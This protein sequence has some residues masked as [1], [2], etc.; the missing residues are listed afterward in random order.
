MYFLWLSEGSKGVWVCERVGICGNHFQSFGGAI[1]ELEVAIHVVRASNGHFVELWGDCGGSGG[2]STALG[3][4]QPRTVR[5]PA[6]YSQIPKA[7]SCLIPVRVGAQEVHVPVIWSGG[8]L[9]LRRV[10]SC[11]VACWSKSL[12]LRGWG[13]SFLLLLLIVTVLIFCRDCLGLLFRSEIFWYL[14]CL[15]ETL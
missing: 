15:W 10:V 7:S 4:R 6:A 2:E 8:G 13:C 9:E 12:L 1:G 3:Y 5:R 11:G 14:L